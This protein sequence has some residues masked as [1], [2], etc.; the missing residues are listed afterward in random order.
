M[1]S[2]SLRF[3]CDPRRFFE[4]GFLGHYRGLSLLS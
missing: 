2:E 4:R 1:G 3:G